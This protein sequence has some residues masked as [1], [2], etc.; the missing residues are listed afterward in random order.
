MAHDPQEALEQKKKILVID[1]E[2]DFLKIF[3]EEQIIY[4]MKKQYVEGSKIN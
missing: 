4:T 3:D 2:E 1:D